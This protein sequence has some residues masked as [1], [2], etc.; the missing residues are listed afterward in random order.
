MGLFSRKLA[1]VQP[2]VQGPI[3]TIP[4]VPQIPTLPDLAD[5]IARG[6]ASKARAALSPSLKANT[7]VNFSDS[8]FL[9][10]I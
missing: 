8:F 3:F 5:K 7:A 6:P 4:E 9:S 1:I 2:V 10:I